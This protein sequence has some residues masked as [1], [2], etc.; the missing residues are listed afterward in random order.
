MNHQTS[1]NHQ[2][3]NGEAH[4]DHAD[5]PHTW[6]LPDLY[7]RKLLMRVE[8]EVR[9]RPVRALGVAAGIGATLGAIVASRLARL[10]L[11]TAG[12][13]VGMEFLRGRVKAYFVE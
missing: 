1:Q 6:T 12:S 7:P 11:V 9:Q 13:Y 4:A 5:R 3:A 8:D 10:L 2:S